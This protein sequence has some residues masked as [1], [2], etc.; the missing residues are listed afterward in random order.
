MKLRTLRRI[1]V[2]A[3][4]LW[5]AYTL[6]FS[7]HL[8]TVS[9]LASG[10][11]YAWRLDVKQQSLGES[12][13]PDLS[14]Q[15]MQQQRRPSANNDLP[16]HHETSSASNQST[17]TSLLDALGVM[18][19]HFF[20][21]SHGTWPEAIDWTAAVMGTQVSAT[22]TAMTKHAN[23]LSSPAPSSILDHE[24][25]INRYFTQITSFYFGENAFSLRTQAYD[26]MLWVVLGWLEAINFITLHSSLH[27]P[28]SNASHW[29]AH[30]F[31]PQFAHRARLFYDLASRGWDDTLCSGGMI[32]NPYLA[33]YKNAIT[34]QLFIAASVEMYLYFPGDA[35]PSPY[36]HMARVRRTE[37]DQGDLP[38]VEAHDRRYLENAI[39]AYR[40][41]KG[42]GIVNGQGLYADGFHISGWR[43]G[44]NGTG[45][46]D[47]RDEKVYTYNQGVVLSGLRG[48]WLATGDVAYLQDGH[49]LVRNVVRATGFHDRHS[50]ERRYRWAGL[51]RNGILEE[52][53]DYAGTCTQNAQAFKGIFFRHFENFCQPLPVLRDDGGRR[54][55]LGDG[56]VRSLHRRSCEGYTGWVAANARAA[57]E[58]RDEEGAFGGWWGRAWRG[59]RDPGDGEM[60]A[61]VGDGGTDYRNEGVPRDGIWRLSSSSSSSLPD[62]DDDG[63]AWGGGGRGGLRQSPGPGPAP[64]SA[65][66]PVRNLD[67]DDAG[68]FDDVNDRGRGRTVETQSGGLAVLR[69]LCGLLDFEGGGG[70][71]YD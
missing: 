33:P 58:T 23:S 14:Q 57:M 47:L 24:N 53:C 46:C 8:R 63:E 42:S 26:D 38:P 71:D 67:D 18:Q 36:S 62:D 37:E 1:G 6:T 10:G 64:A 35:I 15:E 48:L 2:P 25:L 3:G 43:G 17:Y 51:G 5:F 34:N 69:A 55:W 16:I 11:P 44:S 20:V 41:L 9:S 49:D 31:I 65:P 66:R 40:W 12:F 56:G 68:D 52:A 45:N 4:L 70:G 19:S 54:P 21:V 13:Q 61:P 59:E 50:R 39:K 30:Q 29:Y 7:W 22:L 60:E 27:Y 28:P 32:W